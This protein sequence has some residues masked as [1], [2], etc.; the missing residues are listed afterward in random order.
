M[1]KSEYLTVRVMDPEDAVDYDPVE[2]VDKMLFMLDVYDLKGGCFDGAH[3]FFMKNYHSLYSRIP[4]CIPRWS[5]T[6]LAW[7][8][9]LQHMTP[10]FE[11]DE[12]WACRQG[13]YVGDPST[14]TVTQLITALDVLAMQWHRAADW[15]EV[16][17]RRYMHSLWSSA[18]KWTLFTHPE[19]DR[20]EKQGDLWKMRPVDIVACMSRYYWFHQTLDQLAWFEVEL[21]KTPTN[22]W[23]SWIAREE[24]HLVVRKFRDT[25]AKDVWA[26]RLH[27]GDM[28]IASH[29]QL[30]EGMS[31][32]AALYKR[33]PVCLL[34]EIQQAISYGGMDAL[35][36]H[37]D[38][39]QLH[40]IRTYFLNNHQMDFVKFFVCT[41][42][43]MW[44]HREALV[45]SMVPVILQRFG[46]FA[47]LHD[48]LIRAKGPLSVVFPAWVHAAEKPYGMDLKMLREKMFRPPKETTLHS[49]ELP[50]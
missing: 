5:K 30:G 15:D 10:K 21:T 25:L 18:H 50:L 26:N 49:F 23:S 46:T 9:L 38:I 7:V 34:Q 13:I 27:Y 29:K 43:D 1:Y 41:E 14:F 37:L 19:M 42:R 35:Q 31:S 16:Q 44:K 45:G 36:P 11:H 6:M 12:A 48:G 22:Y 8:V 17:L 28:E 33:Q 32:Y 24:R 39:V 20:G 47:L 2:T 3:R 40:M 4:G